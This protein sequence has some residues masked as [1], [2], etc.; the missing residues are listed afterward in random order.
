MLYTADYFKSKGDIV[1]AKKYYNQAL[2][3]AKLL[4]DKNLQNQVQSAIDSL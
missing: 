2:T 1:D 3:Q 4:K